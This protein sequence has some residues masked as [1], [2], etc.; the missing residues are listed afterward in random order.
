MPNVLRFAIYIG[1]VCIISASGVKA[2]SFIYHTDTTNVDTFSRLTVNFGVFDVQTC[3]DSFIEMIGALNFVDIAASP[4]NLIYTYVNLGEDMNAPTGIFPTEIER[5]TLFPRGQFQDHEQ[6]TALS[7]NGAGLIYGAGTGLSFYDPNTLTITYVGDLPPEMQA[8]GDLTFREGKLYLSTISNTLVEVNVDNPMN[9]EVFMTFP[10][11]TPPVHGM[12]TIH[13]DCDVITYAIATHDSGSI[14]YEID[15]DSKTLIE[16]C[17]TDFRIMGAASPDECVIPTCNVLVDL[18]K[19]NSSGATKFD[20]RADT[21]CITPI[22]I[23]DADVEV[24]AVETIDS[25]TL[26]LSGI[27]NIGQEYLNAIGS[28]NLTISGNGTATMTIINNGNATLEELTE[29]IRQVSY[30]N[31]S[32]SP[33]FGER[34]VQVQAFT[35]NFTSEVATS[36]INLGSSIQIEK[37]VTDISCNGTNDGS[38]AIVANDGAAPYT[39]LWS[40]NATDT[41][42]TGLGAG[43]Y[44]ITVTDA[45]GCQTTDTLQLTQPE[46][47]VATITASA[48]SV[49]GQL[50][51]LTAMAT[52]GTAPY[53]FLW[54]DAGQTSAQIGNL[55]AGNYTVSVT[56][57]NSCET[58]AAY[59]LFASDTIRTQEQITRCA[60]AVFDWNGIAIT[61]DTSFCTTF[62]SASGCDSLH[63][64]SVDFLDTVLV[65]E[66]INICQGETYNFNGLQLSRDTSICRVFTA[67]NGCDSTYCFTLNV[68][69]RSSFLSASICAGE[70]YAFAGQMLTES[71]SYTQTISD[72][73]SCDSVVTLNLNVFPLPNP[74][75]TIEGGLCEGGT[76]TLRAGAGFTDYRWSTGATTSSI[77]VVTTGTYTVTVTDVNGCS[78]MASEDIFDTNLTAMVSSSD[79]TCAGGRDGRIRVESVAGG[80]PPY[81]YAINGQPFRQVNEFDRLSGGQYRVTVE[82]VNGCF[83]ETTV[84]LAEPTPVRLDLGED[85]VLALGDSITLEALTNAMNPVI[86]WS[87]PDGLSCDSCLMPV[88][89]P[90]VSTRYEATLTDANGCVA[91]D[92]LNI[93]INRQQ[94][95]FVPTAFSPNGDGVNDTFTFFAKSAIAKVNY[96]RVFDR[97]GNLLYQADHF[98]PNNTEIGWDGTFQGQAMA[99][100]VYIYAIEIEKV[101]GMTEVLRGEVTLIR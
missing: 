56:D 30:Q 37:T 80:S 76:A 10:E 92:D 32:P 84:N 29:A 43:M 89:K 24:F 46:P 62:E 55:G 28:T 18:D 13:S 51:E 27:Q 57:A 78:N 77:Q 35:P 41:L 98:T 34:E 97:W 38:I 47:L 12:A 9:S 83:F 100:G 31:D 87:P 26:T 91:K 2:Q 23:S 48:D 54:S 71:G 3:R 90:I 65:S 72:G 81:F 69:D 6:V 21:A 49:C 52:G 74:E 99:V 59:E 95:S 14:I 86:R 1:I 5:R 44:Q 8:A 94:E 58:T 61:Q 85:V 101:D 7:C 22:L 17:R 75:I 67:A 68:T 93:L 88:A 63:C 82:D 19:D 60:G 66:Q 50:G 40:D 79:P 96:F 36:F 11:G 45:L 42:R 39:Y 53:S 73:G 70:S 33:T 64:V 15:F 16:K 4:S 25:I 20:F